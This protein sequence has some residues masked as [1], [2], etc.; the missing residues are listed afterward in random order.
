MAAT[1]APSESSCLCC[2]NDCVSVLVWLSARAYLSNSFTMCAR[3][4]ECASPIMTITVQ[5]FKR[6][7]RPSPLNQA[8]SL[9][10]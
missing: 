2:Q 3:L 7:D 6:E 10:A 1:I 8:G 9:I 4:L 5:K